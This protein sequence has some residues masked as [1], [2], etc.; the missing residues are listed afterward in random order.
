MKVKDVEPKTIRIIANE[1]VKI[2]HSTFET[3]GDC[4]NMSRKMVSNLIWRG[5]AENI[6]PT[7]I[8]DAIYFKVTHSSNKLIL[9]KIS[10]WDEAFEKRE[11]KRA[12]ISKLLSLRRRK[13]ELL[14]YYIDN[15]EMFIALSPT[16][17]PLNELV[18]DLEHNKK[19]VQ[20]YLFTLK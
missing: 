17:I 4:H 12:K 16:N 7:N 19:M 1:Y 8:A 18:D 3:I 9:S 11:Q 15:Y 5:I 13:V 14:E 20:Y 2:T 10:R 6:L